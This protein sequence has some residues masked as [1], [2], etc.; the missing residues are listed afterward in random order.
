MKQKHADYQ[1]IPYAKMRQLM[2]VAYRSVRHKPMI[3]GL[4]EVDVTRARTLLSEHKAQT[5]ES[6]SF[7]AF[8]IA[9]VAR[10]VDENK[11]VQAIRKGRKHLIVFEDVDVATPI[12]RDVSGNK[13]SI[14]YTIRAANRKSFREI[15]HEIR[16]A[17]AEDSEAVMKA[18]KAI[19]A[20]LFLPSLLF[21]PFFWIGSRI[22]R[23]YPQMQKQSWGTVGVTAVGMFGKGAG[24]GIPTATPTLMITLGGIGEKPGI[25]DGQIVIREYLSLTVSF[26]HDIIDGAPAARFTRRLK[27]LIESAYGLIEQETGAALTEEGAHLQKVR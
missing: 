16:A 24:W 17:Q 26:D 15:H 9:C 5:G 2:S 22:A 14:Q 20:L 25:I 10:A 21:K 23:A 8:I 13:P 6:L 19:Q 3:Y 1:V 11:V 12:E 18:F 4:L 7:T 27:D